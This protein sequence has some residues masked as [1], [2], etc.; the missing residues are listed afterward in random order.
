M[1]SADELVLEAI[2]S[3]GVVQ[4]SQTVDETLGYDDPTGF[5]EVLM[6]EAHLKARSGMGDERMMSATLDEL[7]GDALKSA[8]SKHGD[9]F[10][11]MWTG[12]E[13]EVIWERDKGSAFPEERKRH[14]FVP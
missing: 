1:P 7:V 8:A 11:A 14:V 2:K 3:R 10:N 12:T 13:K 4:P 6:Q 5:T 9:A